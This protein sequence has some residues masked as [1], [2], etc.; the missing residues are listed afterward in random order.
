MR[1]GKVLVRQD[2]I[3]LFMCP[4]CGKMRHGSVAMFKN[5]NH[6]LRVKCGCGQ[7]FPVDLNFRSNFR[8]STNIFGYYHRIDDK[9]PDPTVD[10][11]NCIVID[12]SLGGIGLQLKDNGTLVVGDEVSVEF[13]LDDSKRSEVK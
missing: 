9:R 7:T 4:H 8:K 3:A 11:S 13:I 12:L 6:S 2:N 5:S 1:V 10:E